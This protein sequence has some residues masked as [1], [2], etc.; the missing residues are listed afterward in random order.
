M[1]Y[2]HKKRK[3]G[4]SHHSFISCDL[5]I[6]LTEE[7]KP[8]SLESRAEQSLSVA[9]PSGW[10]PVGNS[11]QSRSTQQCFTAA[12]FN[13]FVVFLAV[14]TIFGVQSWMPIGTEAR[15][16]AGEDSIRR[17]ALKAVRR[18][19]TKPKCWFV[20]SAGEVSWAVNRD[21][22][23]IIQEQSPC[24]YRHGPKKGTLYVTPLSHLVP[25]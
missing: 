21:L 9:P 10:P 25:L 8:A 20:V 22:A 5:W 18:R 7:R 24:I 12:P 4:A 19:L 11:V 17:A 13:Y 1:Q 6:T 2:S 3:K 16:S 15:R 23:V 14:N